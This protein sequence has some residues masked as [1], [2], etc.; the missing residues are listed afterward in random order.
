MQ[1]RSKQ[2]RRIFSGVNNGSCSL[3]G[4][5]HSTTAWGEEIGG[6]DT[7]AN[8]CPRGLDFAAVSEAAVA[9]RGRGGRGESRVGKALS[10]GMMSLALHTRLHWDCLRKKC[11]LSKVQSFC[12]PP[13][14]L[15]G[16]GRH[17]GDSSARRPMAEL[18]GCIARGRLGPELGQHVAR[19]LPLPGLLCHQDRC[20]Q[21]AR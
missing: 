19:A 20:A 3:D 8:I 13:R 21:T 7:D 14:C 15:G 18:Q 17:S 12:P 4:R 5:R 11:C 9:G 16:R 10:G 1:T 6:G 2:S